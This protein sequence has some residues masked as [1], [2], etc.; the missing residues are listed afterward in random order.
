ME[1]TLR[2]TH[3]LLHTPGILEVDG[4][5]FCQTLEDREREKKVKGKTAIPIGRYKI[6]ITM[7]PR[8]KKRMPL[9]HNVPDFSG[10]RIHPGNT[11]DHT[12]GCI[13][14]GQD[15]NALDAWLGSSR[16]TYE[17]LFAVIDKA[18]KDKEEVWITIL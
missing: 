15:T 8:F 5:E 12:E 18:L 9:L 17:K 1:L 10:V 6:T 16:V 11:V 3:N 13:L 7:S 4:V 14:V 2:R